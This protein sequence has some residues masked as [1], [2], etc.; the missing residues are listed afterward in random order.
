MRNPKIV[1]GM[2]V[3]VLFALPASAPAA[4]KVSD[5]AKHVHSAEAAL[6][7]AAMAAEQGKVRRAGKALARERAQARKAARKAA[8]VRGAKRELNAT[9]MAARYNDAAFAELADLVGEVPGRARGVVL[10]ALARAAASRDALIARLTTLA[11]RLPDR[12]RDAV[13]SAIARMQADDAP[14]TLAA[15]LDEGSLGEAATARI[16][17][18]IDK[19]TARLEAVAVRLDEL[20]ATLPA[21]A[22]GPVQAAAAAIRGNLARIGSILDGSLLCSH[23]PV[24]DCS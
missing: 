24:L 3:A 9:R 17:E 5:V 13:M 18:V 2:T 20:G 11:E 12:A 21:E 10:D 19:V 8:R 23:L 16:A 22:Q 6:D 14:T 7:L 15:L 1:L 4:P